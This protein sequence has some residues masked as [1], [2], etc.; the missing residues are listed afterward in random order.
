MSGEVVDVCNVGIAASTCSF[1]EE[2]Y[3]STAAGLPVEILIFDF[4]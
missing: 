2:H 4:D 1:T 3:A